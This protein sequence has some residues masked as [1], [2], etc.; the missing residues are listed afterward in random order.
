MLNMQNTQKLIFIS[1]VVSCFLNGCATPQ[2]QTLKP[3]NQIV[4]KPM[5]LES[6]S[7]SA[8]TY[9]F[10]YNNDPAIEKAYQEYLRT[11]KA[12]N[13]IT[14]GFQQFAYGNTQPIINASP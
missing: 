11:G 14:Q 8:D 10:V 1:I 7:I 5:T 13:I 9:K 3:A 6:Q 12:P 2:P 4:N